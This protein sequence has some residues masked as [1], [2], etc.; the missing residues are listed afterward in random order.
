MTYPDY[1]RAVEE[2]YPNYYGA[3][4]IAD[5]D[6]AWKEYWHEPDPAKKAVILEEIKRLNRKIAQEVVCGLIDKYIEDGKVKC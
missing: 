3:Q 4:I 6:D 5:E 2:N 1:W